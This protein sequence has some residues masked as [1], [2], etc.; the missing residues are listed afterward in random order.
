MPLFEYACVECGR[1]DERLLRVPAPERV[2][3][4]ACGA[5]ARRL[6]PLLARSGGECSPAVSGST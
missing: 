6:V 5:E 4:S 2:P 1:T 3:C